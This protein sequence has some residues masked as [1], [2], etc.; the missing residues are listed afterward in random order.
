[1]RFYTPKL[2]A[3]GAMWVAYL[4]ALKD[5]AARRSSDIA[6]MDR[7]S[8]STC[9]PTN[10]NKARPTHGRRGRG[11][12]AYCGVQAYDFVTSAGASPTN[13]LGARRISVC[14][15]DAWLGLFARRELRACPM[16]TYS[17]TRLPRAPQPILRE[18][19]P[20]RR[21]VYIAARHSRHW[22]RLGS[23]SRNALASCV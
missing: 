21:V 9:A 2:F 11:D 17:H 7:P 14:V 18:N 8:L 5:S 4:Q 22:S 15:F 12:G 20:A 23:N 3:L 13:R 1:M 16:L 19:D 6:G 10:P